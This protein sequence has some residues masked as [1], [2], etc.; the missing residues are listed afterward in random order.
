MP[1]QDVFT[2]TGR[3]T[4][5]PVVSSALVNVNEESRSSASAGD[6]QAHRYRCGDVFQALLDQGQA[7]DNVGLLDPRGV[8]REDV[9]P[10][11]SS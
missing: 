9:E 11:R 6:H 8:K 4:S 10:V 5:S 3:C 2:I 7:G 1:V